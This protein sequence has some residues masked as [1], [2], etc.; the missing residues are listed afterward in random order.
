MQ[1]HRLLSVKAYRTLVEHVS[2]CSCFP[3]QRLQ[4]WTS[5]QAPLHSGVGWPLSF[6]LCIYSLWSKL[7]NPDVLPGGPPEQ[8]DL[9]V[10][11]FT[12]ILSGPGLPIW[13]S[14]QAVLHCWSRMTSMF[15]SLHLYSSGRPARR[16][17]TL[18][19]GWPPSFY[20]YIY[21]LLDVLPGGPPLL[22]QDDL[23]VSIFTFILFWTS[24]QAALHSWSRMT[25]KFLS[26]H[27]YSL[28]Q[29]Y[30][31]G[32]PARRPYTPGAGW[33]PSFFL[34]IFYSSERPARRPSTLGAGWP[35]GFY[36]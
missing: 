21:T 10:S 22:E 4:I 1:W 32:R 19:A 35:P 34:Y 28:V 26:L 6:S 30:R 31:S 16:R 12:F 27:L 24:C 23:Q 7:T 36:L 8:D 11:I 25:S 14:C 20:L 13:T 2:I 3:R 15:L 9:Q 5:C 29:A 33:P 18:G 17:S